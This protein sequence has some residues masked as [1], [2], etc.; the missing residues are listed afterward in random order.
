ME[1]SK[2]KQN[3][4]AQTSLLFIQNNL[5]NTAKEQRNNEKNEHINFSLLMAGTRKI[6]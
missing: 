6:S 4:N 2:T 1:S 5:L 3:I